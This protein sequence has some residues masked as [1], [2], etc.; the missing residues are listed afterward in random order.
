MNE[1]PKIR[2]HYQVSVTERRRMPRGITERAHYENRPQYVQRRTWDTSNDDKARRFA[3]FNFPVPN[4]L[5][6]KNGVLHTITA[7]I[8]WG[9]CGCR[10]QSPDFE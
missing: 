8:V 5:L 1:E 4:W 10:C 3:R 9:L 2:T 7:S 6:P